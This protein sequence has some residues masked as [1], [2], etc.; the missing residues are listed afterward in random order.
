MAI[1]ILTCLLFL[2]A[3]RKVVLSD[4]I[5]MAEWDLNTVVVDDYSVMLHIDENGYRSWLN[6]V[7]H[8]PGGDNEKKI[9]PGLSLK[10]YMI[11][12][13]EHQLTKEMADYRDMVI[14]ENASSVN[15]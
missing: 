14:S 7:F 13:I 11:Q 1:G 9:S 12:K 5:T 10:K 15:D 8:G 2:I 4:K 6:E 3:I